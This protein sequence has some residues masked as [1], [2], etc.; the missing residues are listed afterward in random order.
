MSV[1]AISWVLKHSTTDATDRLCLL[2]LANYADAEGLAWPGV[3]LIAHD[4]RVSPRTAQRALRSLETAGHIDVDVN[5]APDSRMRADRRSNAYRII[6]GRGDT[7]VTPSES[8]RGVTSEARGDSQR[9]DGVTPGAPRG[10]NQRAHGVSQVSPKPSVEPKKEPSLEPV[11]VTVSSSS[12]IARR[13]LDDDDEQLVTITFEEAAE[14]EDGAAVLEAVA[15]NLAQR[16]LRRR[17]AEAGPVGNRRAWLAVAAD[18]AA[19]ELAEQFWRTWSACPERSVEELTDLLDP[20]D[21]RP[22]LAHL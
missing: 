19:A 4:M 9:A 1:Q 12:S 2:V 21:R 13:P 18:R 11:R 8:G 20:W 5:G 14:P 10:D 7:C 3:E 22:T 6:M 16:R 15:A 17:L